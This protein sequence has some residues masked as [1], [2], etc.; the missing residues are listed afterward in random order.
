MKTVVVREFTSPEIPDAYTLDLTENTAHHC[1]GCWTC[2]WKTP[3]RCAFHD[4]DRFYHEYVTADRAVYFAKVTKGF[5][6]ANLKTLF[7]RMLPLYLPY[8]DYTT[9]ESMHVPRYGKYPEIEFY[10]EGEFAS[11]EGRQIFE[12]YIRRVFYQFYSKV[13]TI[14]PF[15]FSSAEVDQ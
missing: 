14:E 8:M 3:G 7:D 13:L 6:S 4:L 10:Y 11:A 15:H 1:T 12:D 2:W 9:G 5:V